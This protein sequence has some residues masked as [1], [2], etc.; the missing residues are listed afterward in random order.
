MSFMT[1][2]VV[3][4]I[5]ANLVNLLM[6]GIFLSRPLGMVRLERTLGWI[7]IALAIPVAVCVVV[8]ALAGRGVW[9]V[10]LPS[11]LV[12]FLLVELVFDY[13]LETNFRQSR[14][15]GPYLL[16]YYLALMG[17]IGYAFLVSTTYGFITL[18]TYF[19]NL[20]A[21]WYSYAQVGHGDGPGR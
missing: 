11:L 18:A 20:L 6:V 13:I 4:F 2:D 10:L 19:L 3:L 7:Q 21:T 17:M 15:L 5:V 12:V 16:L 1:V 9:Y 8:N 14:W